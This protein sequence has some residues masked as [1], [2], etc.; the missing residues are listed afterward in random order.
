[1]S[2]PPCTTSAATPAPASA[3]SAPATTKPATTAS[4]TI[5]SSEVANSRVSAPNSRAAWANH[6][7]NSSRSPPSRASS[8]RSGDGPAASPASGA[9]GAA[10][11]SQAFSGRSVTASAA[12]V[13]RRE[14]GA[15]DE[16]D[17]QRRQ[18]IL[19]HV[20]GNLADQLLALAAREFLA[21]AHLLGRAAG[22][23]TQT[24]LGGAESVGCLVDD[25][26][27]LLGDLI[28]GS[29]RLFNRFLG[30]HSDSLL[31]GCETSAPRASEA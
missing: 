27:Q 10:P 19:A 26:M 30:G 3:S 5:S 31:V 9:C 25:R 4:A 21:L 29:V 6:C 14:Q 17:A 28:D 22:L 12:T 1:G 24:L 18:R 2:M 7:A 23:R 8:S 16:G 20:V 13:Q 11:G 15:G